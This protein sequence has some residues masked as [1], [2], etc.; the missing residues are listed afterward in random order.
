MNQFTPIPGTSLAINWAT[1][2]PKFRI[3]TIDR[4]GYC[5][6]WEGMPVPKNDGFVWIFGGK[7]VCVFHNLNNNQ[8][9][10]NWRDLIFERPN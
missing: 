1:I 2:D 7:S 4:S 6:A 9:F 8:S 5:E 3:A 10:D